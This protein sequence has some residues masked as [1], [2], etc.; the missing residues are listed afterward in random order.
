[1]AVTDVAVG[2]ATAALTGAAA[3]GLTAAGA[4]LALA[5]EDDDDEAMFEVEV[6]A[7]AALTACALPSLATSGMPSRIASASYSL[8]S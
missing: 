1:M 3:T 6:F 8:P 7:G 4:A 5:D 2:L